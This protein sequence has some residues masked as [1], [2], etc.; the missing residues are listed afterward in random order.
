MGGV[1][2]RVQAE[3]RKSELQTG[4]P[5]SGRTGWGGWGWGCETKWG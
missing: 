2:H 1:T 5:R 3:D 4:R